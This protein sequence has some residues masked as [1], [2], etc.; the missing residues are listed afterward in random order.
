[1]LSTP[2][3]AD[4]LQAWTTALLH[5][6]VICVHAALDIRRLDQWS[7]VQDIFE[8]NVGDILSDVVTLL[9]PTDSAFK[10]L[11]E[12][13][14]ACALLMSSL[15]SAASWSS[16]V[17]HAGCHTLASADLITGMGMQVGMEL[18][19]L[20]KLPIIKK[21]ILYHIL[22]AIEEFAEIAIGELIESFLL[23][24][25]IKVSRCPCSVTRSA[26]LWSLAILALQHAPSPLTRQTMPSCSHAHVSDPAQLQA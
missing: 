18:E 17:S 26:K 14:R 8:L 11:A 21:I 9:A 3:T 20:I 10:A 25:G 15:L 5:C 24:E 1:M 13:V 2:G 16:S 6:V 23:K 4:P 19:E 22:P 12:K 7:D